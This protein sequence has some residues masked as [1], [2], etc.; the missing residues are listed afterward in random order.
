MSHHAEGQAGSGPR[1][2]LS[3]PIGL[4]S[5]LLLL[6]PWRRVPEPALVGIAAIAGL[7]VH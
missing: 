3:I 5:L 6:Q 4:C 2:P 1:G 7:L